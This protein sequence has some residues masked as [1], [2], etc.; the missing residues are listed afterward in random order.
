[1]LKF[2]I[3]TTKNLLAFSA[4]IDSSALFFL[5]LEQNIPFDIA[6]VDYNTRAQS[7]DEV[8]YAKE[9][10]SKYQ[11]KCFLKSVTLEN[12]SNFEKKAREIRY[13]FFEEIIKKNQY[14]TLITAHQL[15]DKLEWFLMQLTKGAG[16]VEL[17][18]LEKYSKKKSYQIYRPLLD[19]SKER[20]LEYLEKHNLKYFI[21]DS[22]SD[23][24]Y[25]RNYFRKNFANDLI[26]K[27]ENGIKNSFNYLENDLNSLNIDYQAIYENKLLE[28]FK[29]LNDDN[30]NIKIIDK[31]L[32][33][34]AYLI[35]KAQRDEILKQKEITISNE[36][37]ITIGEKYI[38][39]SPKC[40]GSMD[41]KFKE[42]CRVKKIPKNIRNYL[43]KEKI[44]P[45]DL[46]F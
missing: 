14:E 2:D 6:I 16:L 30:L 41:K 15:N 17:I 13:S 11:K 3:N 36:I 1:M 34:R 10:A 4:G 38:Y 37:N 25:K 29:N 8:S 35:S 26:K 40:E 45:N 43:F 42:D 31:S 39:I 18:G 44:N 19:L 46:M 7:K 20:L 32:K 12:K 5:L 24:K 9:L 23:E 21:D 22:N 27:Y 28:V 33:K